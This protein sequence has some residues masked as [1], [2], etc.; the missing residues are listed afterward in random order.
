MSSPRLFSP[1]RLRDL[2]L[3]NRV[4]IAPMC[5][6]ASTDGLASDWH[7]MHWGS[8]TQSAA[9]LFI[10]EA[11]GVSPQG[12]I[13]PHCL[14]LWNDETEAAM[15]RV[16]AAVRPHASTPIAIQLAHAGR[17]ASCAAPWQG[18]QRVNHDQGGWLPEGPSAVAFRETDPAPHAFTEAEIH[19][20]IQDFAQATV[21]AE[22]LGLDAIELHCAHGYLLHQFLSPV[23]NQR[24]DAWGGN[25]ENRMRLPLAV[26]DAMRA[27]WPAHK[28]LGVR[29]SATDGLEHTPTPSWALPDTI[30]FAQAL[31]VR[32]CDWID[33]SSGGTSPQQRI[34]AVP[35]YQVPLAESIRRETT[36]PTMAVGLITE[37]AQAEQIL[38]QGQADLVALA[39]GML[40]NPRWVWHAAAQLGA[41][42]VL[43]RS[44]ERGVPAGM[45][46]VLARR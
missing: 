6:Y 8:M 25:L 34:D 18:G 5:M 26:F 14:G 20:V 38:E 39:R 28:P 46:H 42:V 44:Y 4:V 31:Q 33:V 13:T 37:P 29:V 35:L 27:V 11:T 12:R 17:K 23:S 1:F 36:L 45:G 2:E 22:R 10:I 16:L 40:W 41:Q 24:T 9:G 15:A 43:P 19:R 21:R 30:A 32:G 7:T 3:P